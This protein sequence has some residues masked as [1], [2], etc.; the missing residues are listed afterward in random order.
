MSEIARK[1]LTDVATSLGWKLTGLTVTGRVV[2]DESASP[3]DADCYDEVSKAAWCRDDWQ[4]VGFLVEVTDAAGRVWGADSL[5]SVEYGDFPVTD[6]HGTLI[7]TRRLDP[8]GEDEHTYP[9]DQVISEAL[10]NAQENLSSFT[11]PTIVS[12]VVVSGE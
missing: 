12:P 6:E 8:L 3:D 1:D 11:L 10:G 7:E 5:W 4:Y 9:R 2:A